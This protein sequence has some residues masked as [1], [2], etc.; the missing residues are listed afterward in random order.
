ML[1][2]SIINWLEEALYDFE[3]ADSLNDQVLPP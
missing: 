1:Q 3:V 2:G